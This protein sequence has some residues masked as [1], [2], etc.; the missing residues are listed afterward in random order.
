VP[1]SRPGICCCVAERG[2]WIASGRLGGSRV[3][4]SHKPAS[5]G[6]ERS[7]GMPEGTESYERRRSG[8]GS[9][10]LSTPRY[11]VTRAGLNVKPSKGERGGAA[12]KASARL[13]R[14]RLWKEEPQ[15]GID[16]RNPSD[17][18]RGSGD[19]TNSPREQGPE[20]GCAA[21]VPPRGVR[22]RRATSGGHGPREGHRSRRGETLE[23]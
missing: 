11:P 2:A 7:A 15:E 18:I 23:G 17:F 16:G 6:G 1:G 19:S 3:R 9:F 4:R 10:H 14:S 20:G 21:L 13:G 12:T 22:D 8:D 5:C